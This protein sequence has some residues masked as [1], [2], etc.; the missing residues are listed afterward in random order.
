[1]RRP[2]LD[3]RLE[4]KKKSSLRRICDSFRYMTQSMIRSQ[5]WHG[6]GVRPT[7]GVLSQRILPLQEVSHLTQE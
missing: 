4:K 1:M 5:A 6:R 7:I 3:P 2:M